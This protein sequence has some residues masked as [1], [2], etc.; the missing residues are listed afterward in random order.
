M[1]I[2]SS[3]NSLCAKC[4]GRLWCGKERCP[5][6]VKFYSQTKVKPLIDSTYLEGSSPPSVFIGRYN[7]PKV[8]IGPMIPPKYGDT[9]FMDTPELWKGK[10]IEE[11]VDLRFQVFN[12]HKEFRGK[13]NRENKGNRAC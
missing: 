1:K 5:I 10:S 9:G 6:L 12:S 11:I 2:F 3:D 8:F 13:D 4:K 7:Y